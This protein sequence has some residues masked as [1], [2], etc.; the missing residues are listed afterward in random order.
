MVDL[1]HSF[2]MQVIAEGVEDGRT[3]ATLLSLD[4]DQAQGY[5]YSPAVPATEVVGQRGAVR[6]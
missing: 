6:T 5:W 4:V 1:A 2:G 3:A